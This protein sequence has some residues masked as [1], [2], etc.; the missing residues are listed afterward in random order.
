MK[1]PRAFVTDH[2]LVRYFERVLGFDI[3]ALKDEIARAVDASVQVGGGSVVLDGMR[4][5]LKA[6]ADGGPT[7]VPIP[8]SA[9]PLNARRSGLRTGGI[10]EVEPDPCA[11]PRCGNTARDRNPTDLCQVHGGRFKQAVRAA[12]RSA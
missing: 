1:K 2:A 3:D 8:P 10:A 6:G 11:V 12:R 9:D 7:V 5:V 4:Y